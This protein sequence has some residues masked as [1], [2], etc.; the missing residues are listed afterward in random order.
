MHT[1]T[2]FE[3][4]KVPPEDV[5]VL[6]AEH[7]ALERARIWRRLLMM[8]FGSLAALL[9]GSGLA[10]HWLPPVAYWTAGALCVAAPI[11]AWIVELTRDWRLTR[12]LQQ[13]PGAVTYVVRSQEVH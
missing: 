1:V 13:V 9:V 2:S 5:T 7:L 11:W 12:H 10:F 3:G 6:I 4:L 8:R